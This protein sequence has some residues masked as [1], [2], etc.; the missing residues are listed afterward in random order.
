MSSREKIELQFDKIDNALIKLYYSWKYQ[1]VYDYFDFSKELSCL[2]YEIK[3]SNEQINYSYRLEEYFFLFWGISREIR[4]MTDACDFK[5]E[6]SGI[7]D[8][9]LIKTKAFYEQKRG[10]KY[11]ID[12]I[13]KDI[14]KSNTLS[15]EWMDIEK[16]QEIIEVPQKWYYSFE[17]YI[18]EKLAFKKKS[19]DKQI[20]E[21]Y[22]DDNEQ[23]ELK[24]S[25]LKFNTLNKLLLEEVSLSYSAELKEIIIQIDLLIAFFAS[26]RCKIASL[27]TENADEK[28]K[29]LDQFDFQITLPLKNKKDELLRLIENKGNTSKEKNPTS[30]DHVCRSLALCYFFLDESKEFVIDKRPGTKKDNLKRIAEEYKFGIGSFRDKYY[31][32]IR[33][34]GDYPITKELVEQYHLIIEWLDRNNYPIAKELAKKRLELIKQKL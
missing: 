15:H 11:D 29:Q 30:Y 19:L 9:Y 18:L 22:L 12:R 7:N 10:L 25:L 4:K 17:K 8:E 5:F 21:D 31:E 14:D 1:V 13:F 27:Y 6:L 32:A 20:I 16:Y 24:S 2:F 3:E 23:S 26:I 33:N 28:K 34:K